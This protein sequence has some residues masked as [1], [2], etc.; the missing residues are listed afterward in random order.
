MVMFIRM[1]HHIKYRRCVVIVILVT[2]DKAFD[3]AGIQ[4]YDFMSEFD[5]LSCSIMSTS[6]GFKANQTHRIIG[7]KA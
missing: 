4:Q 3:I 2:D 1:G 7:K 6:A 5:Q